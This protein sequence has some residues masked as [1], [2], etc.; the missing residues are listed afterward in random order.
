[1]NARRVTAVAGVIH[2]AQKTKQT[3]AGIAAS[4]EAAQLL[5]SPETAAEQLT[6]LA[7]VDRLRAQVAAV[8]GLHRRHTDSDHCFADDEAWPCQTR[9]L[10]APSVAPRDVPAHR[11]GRWTA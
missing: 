8:L 1:M 2:A 11:D 9:A 4:L 3:A 6:L 10:L 7:E 5:Q